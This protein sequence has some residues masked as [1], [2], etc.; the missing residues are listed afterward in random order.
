LAATA[1]E[2]S[3]QAEQLQQLMA[4]FKLDAATH[5]KAVN[6]AH[7]PDLRPVAKKQPG[8]KKMASSLA[9]ATEGAPDEAHFTRF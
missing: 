8:I 1:E 7:K 3:S 9:L 4:F 5:A 2:M 6:V